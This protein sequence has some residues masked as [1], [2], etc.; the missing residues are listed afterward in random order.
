M[1]RNRFCTPSA[2][3]TMPEPSSKPSKGI[4]RCNGPIVQGAGQ[5]AVKTTRVVRWAEQIARVYPNKASPTATSDP[6]PI[7]GR[8]PSWEETTLRLH[9][10]KR[11]RLPKHLR[12][13][14]PPPGFEEAE[15]RI[16]HRLDNITDYCLP[17]AHGWQ[18]SQEKR[19]RRSDAQTGKIL[20]GEWPPAR[21][22]KRKELVINKDPDFG[23]VDDEPTWSG[24]CV[25][26]E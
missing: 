3:T 1:V 21:P 19:V 9:G 22:W 12:A 4:M 13:F 17:G 18:S 8:E 24:Q 16:H 23:L 26:E 10:Y 20:R 25:E 11:A 15:A 6:I 14:Q 7:P 2:S 5:P